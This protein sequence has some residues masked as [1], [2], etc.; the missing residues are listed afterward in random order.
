M[1]EPRRRY[2][3]ASGAGDGK[4]GE[5]MRLTTCVEPLC[6]S[7][8][9]SGPWGRAMNVAV[10]AALLSG[11]L[12]VMLSVFVHP[13]CAQDAQAGETGKSED[14]VVTASRITR[15]G[16]TAPTPTTML[17]ADNVALQGASTLT[18]AVNQIPSFLPNTT[19]ATAGNSTATAGANFL[20]LRGIGAPR[21]L[22]LVNGR[23]FVPSATQAAI[24]GTVDVNLIPQ[25]LIDRVEVVTGG[26]SAAWGSDA[27]A[28]VVNF[29]LDR[30][31]KGLEVGLQAGIS[32]RGDNAETQVSA[33]WGTDLADGRGH[34]V[35]SGEYFDSRGILNQ[36]DRKWGAEGW[37][38][39]V[40]PLYTPTNGEP[41]RILSADVHQS[42]RT[43]GGLILTAGPLRYLQFGPGGTVSPFAT[44]SYLGSTYMV[45]GDGIN[46]GKYI[47]LVT[48]HRRR[49]LYAMFDY[50]IADNV[51][52]SLEGSYARSTSNNETT[53]SFS[54]APYTITQQNAF[55][56]DAVRSTMLTNGIT[57]FQMGRIN[58]DFG[59][60]TTD[61][62]AKVYRA[63]ASL[64]G[65]FG[66]TWRWSAYYTYGETRRLDRSL[67]NVVNARL[68]AAIDSIADP[69][70]G[71]P[72]CRNL[73]T[74]P[75]CVPINLFGYGSPSA[76]AID[77]VTE[78]QVVASKIRQHA[79]ALDFSGEPFSTWAGAVS[80]AF[81]IE[82]RRESVS[83]VAD[84]ISLAN[85]FMI[86]NPKSLAGHYDVKEAYAEAVVPL[87][88]DV[89]F[90]RLLELNGA[91]RYT[92][93]STGASVTTWKLGGT[94]VPM[95]GLKL[96]G[97]LSRDIRAANLTEMFSISGLSFANVRDPR[98]GSSPFISSLSAGNPGLAP[99]KADTWTAGVVLEPVM[100][101][102]LRLS[103]DYYDIDISGA[104]GTLTTQNIIDRCF[105]G[106][107]AQLCDLIE[108]NPDTSIR[109]V[110]NFFVNIQTVQTR[111]VDAELAYRTALGSDSLSVR[112][113][114]TYVA[115]LVTGDGVTSVDRAG[116]AQGTGV[117]HWTGLA[118]IVYATGPLSLGVSGRYVG[119]GAFDVTFGPG[120]I[121]DNSISGRFYINLS[122]Q[123]DIGRGDGWTM[124]LYG[125]VKNLLDKDPPIVGSTFQAPFA[126]NGALYDMVGRY[127][128]VGA[129]VRF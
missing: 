124:E 55:L 107:A 56:P 19:P 52:L 15:S 106:G 63:V 85:G 93:Y 110:N 58:T 84:A 62:D 72:V 40:N 2:P 103:V 27:V 57:Q 97:T 21:T 1:S 25:A 75:R 53:A 14:I 10:R 78:D 50:D 116:Q 7:Q 126:T 20:N 22:V 127:F 32:S 121:N 83:S 48:P 49:S 94:Y 129:R 6:G 41:A 89:P 99:E 122:A 123:Y 88:R 39:F 71:Q 66:D 35:I 12:P 23:R 77:Y 29:I 115:D 28:G 43:E 37:Q 70:T 101:P 16:F 81:G 74:N 67:G 11:G 128:T 8:V 108:L 113:L 98:D 100:L 60:I 13:A 109:H 82:Y 79:A 3:N 112:L 73:A 46:Q 76:A 80:L 33:R 17:D 42:N 117:P 125:A 95:D 61:L 59:Y 34:F 4:E 119:G 38:V 54:L 87:L 69:V 65:N 26:A 31:Q 68:A 92:D 102:G 111:G 45:G 5:T 44:G 24:A 114:G 86:G 30:D 104:I 18:E 105:I 64:D 96:R 90:A 91:V 118:N 47:S 36:Q 9:R 120:D 51:R